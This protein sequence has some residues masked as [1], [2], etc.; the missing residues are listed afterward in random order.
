MWG[1]TDRWWRL[2]TKL[3]PS[4]AGH[5]GGVRSD[6]RGKPAS[7]QG[8]DRTDLILEPSLQLPRPR[9]G[10]A[11]V[12]GLPRRG[13]EQKG[14]VGSC[15]Q[16]GGLPRGRRPGRGTS[17]PQCSQAT[18]LR[19]RLAAQPAGLAPPSV[20]SLW[21]PSPERKGCVTISSGYLTN[22]H[23]LGRLN[24]RKF[25]SRFREPKIRVSAGLLPTEA[26]EGESAPGVC[27]APGQLLSPWHSL[28][29]EASPPPVSFFGPSLCTC[30]HIPFL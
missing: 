4:D 25:L 11:Q 28:A 12:A 23:S 19:P 8:S 7:W 10:G 26:C 27:P 17:R 13:Q 6:L 3:G 9:S 14:E 18:A 21:I 30:V 15:G 20:S 5:R 29:V 1:D 22:H 16:A 2:E 24:C